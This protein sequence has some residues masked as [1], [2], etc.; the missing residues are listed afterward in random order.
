MPKKSVYLQLESRIA[1]DE[2]GGIIHRWNYGREMLKAK[3]GRKQLPDGFTRER[4]VEAVRA[5]LVLSER[6]IQW[7]IKCA[8]VYA[9]DQEVR[10]AIT[11]FGTWFAL[12]QAG[13]PSV[14][15]DET[16]DEI[17]DIEAAGADTEDD[18]HEDPLFDIPGFKAVLKI[19]GRKTDL[20]EITVRDAIN[21]R[22]MCH[23]MHDNFGRTIADIDA[24]VNA[25]IEGSGG[26]MDANAAEA[27][28]RATERPDDGAA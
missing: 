7:R 21:Y 19:R 24:S 16:D 3:A 18:W 27:Y 26:D 15:V 5:G 8:S 14:E 10:K 6:E 22:D 23:E 13:F 17:D 2:R 4:V 20:A 1:T 11:D 28:R 12:T 9:N 25:M